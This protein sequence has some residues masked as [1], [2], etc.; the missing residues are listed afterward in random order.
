MLAVCHTMLMV[1]R[2]R[3]DGRWR[4]IVV[5]ES[6]QLFRLRFC[7]VLGGSGSASGRI[8]KL[9]DFCGMWKE[10]SASGARSKWE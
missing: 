1:M 10:D 5:C 7:G 8:G 9:F 6:P 3:G 2:M 4:M